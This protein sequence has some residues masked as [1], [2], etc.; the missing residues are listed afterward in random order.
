[1]L[2]THDTLHTL[3]TNHPLESVEILLATFAP[4]PSQ[5]LTAAAGWLK[6]HIEVCWL[7]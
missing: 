4:W 6:A 7:C 5:W 2:G 1:M 3:A